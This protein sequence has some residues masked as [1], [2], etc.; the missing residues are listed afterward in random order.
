MTY[1]EVSLGN[2]GKI[3]RIVAMKEKEKW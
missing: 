1:T 2:Y 3:R